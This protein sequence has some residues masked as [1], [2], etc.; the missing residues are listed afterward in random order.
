MQKQFNLSPKSIKTTKMEP[1]TLLLSISFLLIYNSILSHYG[2]D[3]IITSLWLIYL[4]LS[5]NPSIKKLSNLKNQQREI[6]ITKTSISPQDQYA[7][8]TKLNRKHDE[9]GKEIETLEG[10]LLD[11]KNSF[12]KS[13]K[14]GINIIY[15]I[16]MIYFRAFKRKSTILWIPNGVFPHYLE[17]LLSWPSVP[18]GSIGLTQ[19]I[20]LLN[21]FL[22]GVQFIIKNI[23]NKLEPPK[24]VSTN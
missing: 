17:K 13:C 24:E 20:F 12:D 16:P 21:S 1:F 18:I 22:S 4:K 7:K 3:S 10:Q 15:W 9:L 14:M 11:V 19:W 8:W 5:S 6:Y 2:K 23:N